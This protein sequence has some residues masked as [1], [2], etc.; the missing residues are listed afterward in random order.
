MSQIAFITIG[1]RDLQVDKNMLI[2]KIGE[3]ATQ[4]CY[5][6]NYNNREEF[7]PRTGA[8]ILL[9]N[10]SVLDKKRVQLPILEPFLELSLLNHP[11]GFDKVFLVATNQEKN[12]AG[13]RYWANDTVGFA[14]IIK[15]ILDTRKQN[16]KKL[17]PQ[18]E[19]IEVRE[20]VIY[21]D[22]M[23]AWFKQQ[24]KGKKFHDLESAD[25]ILLFNQG[26][27]DAINYGLLLLSLYSYGS[28]VQLFNVNEQLGVC[29]PL[30]FQQ[31]FGYEQEKKRLV[32]G[33]ERHDYAAAK[34]ME[35]PK[36]LQH[37]TAYAEARLNFDFDTALQQL[38]LLSNTH[39]LWRDQAIAEI[40]AVRS[41]E[42]SLTIELFWNAHIR[43]KQEA[44]VDFVQ[45]YFRIIE[46]LA[47]DE[48]VKFLD[49]DYNHKTWLQDFGAFLE[50]P[51]QASLKVILDQ[52]KVYNGA[53]LKID[54]A[55]IPV[56]SAILSHYYPEMHQFIER[57]IPLSQLRNKG[58]GAHGFDP[59]GKRHILEKLKTDDAG[60]EALLQKTAQL[61]GADNN[62]FDRINQ[63]I[64]QQ[65]AN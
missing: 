56:L 39:R 38:G 43:L 11:E 40:N 20:N 65:L 15:K 46:Q 59:I 24:F 45:R 2:E 63:M 48:V 13:E 58:I 22:S 14:Q 9:E 50:K 52:T 12:I 6:V 35:L 53:P 33:L 34:Y 57:L 54:T 55:T 61:I 49:F 62:P 7:V 26:G 41:N 42:Q 37:M 31:Q 28:K 60:L 3:Q 44:Y 23:F 19:I 30:E 29:T 21:L 4:A 27:I 10:F 32:Q 47:K 51:E 16:G 8:E 25:R 64:R 18:I 1:T 17:Y 36:D 5:R